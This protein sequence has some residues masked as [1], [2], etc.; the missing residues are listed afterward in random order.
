[1]II[2]DRK[3]LIARNFKINKNLTEFYV[4]EHDNSLNLAI[5]KSC[6]NLKTLITIFTESELEILKVILNSCQHLDNIRVQY[7]IGYF[8]DREFLEVLEIHSPKNLGI[9]IDYYGKSKKFL[10]KLEEFFIF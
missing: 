5:A 10:D 9:E 8:I 2:Y 1:M 7:C 4:G 6:P 3:I